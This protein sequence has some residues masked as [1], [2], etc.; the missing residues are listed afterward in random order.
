MGV[1]VGAD[2]DV[3]VAQAPVGEVWV[4]HKL[5]EAILCR[6]VKKRLLV[7]VA[8]DAWAVGQSVV[9]VAS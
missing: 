4:G 6:Q 5:G 3:D 2:V 8:V 7:S 9:E 1:G